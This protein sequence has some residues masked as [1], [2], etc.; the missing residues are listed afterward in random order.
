MSPRLGEGSGGILLLQDQA[1]QRMLSSQL[2]QTQT[3]RI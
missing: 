1:P 2:V 3:G